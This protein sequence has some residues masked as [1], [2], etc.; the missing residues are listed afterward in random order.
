MVVRCCAM[1]SPHLAETVVGNGVS[2]DNRRAST[3]HHRPHPT[4]VVENSE[5]QGCPRTAVEL[6]D[7]SLLR[8][9]RAACGSTIV[10]I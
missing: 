6:F 8:K 2:V 10:C 5:L 3:R 4:M 1:R 9:L 7:V